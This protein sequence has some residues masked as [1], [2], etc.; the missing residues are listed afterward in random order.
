[1]SQQGTMDTLNRARV[2]LKH[3][4]IP[5]DRSVIEAAR[6]HVHDFL[7]EN[8]ANIFG[9]NF[10]EVALSSLVSCSAEARAHLE[11]AESHM[12]AGEYDDAMGEIAYALHRLLNDHE[13]HVRANVQAAGGHRGLR[14]DSLFI[15][16][17]LLAPHVERGL[18]QFADDVSERIHELQVAVRVLGLGL[19]FGQWQRFMNLAPSVIEL[20]PGQLNRTEWHRETPPTVDECRFCYDFVIDSALRLQEAL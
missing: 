19:D 6:V 4:A 5:P 8:T 1:V 15:P 2:S 7:V 18:S 12:A 17:N 3:H 16:M 20:R 10:E 9:L 11:K 14:L 13:A